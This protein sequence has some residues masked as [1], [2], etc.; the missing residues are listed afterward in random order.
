MNKTVILLFLFLSAMFPF[1]CQK[2]GGEGVKDEGP[3]VMVMSFNVRTSNIR[4]EK[5]ENNWENRRDACCAMINYTRPVL[6]GVQ[7][8]RKEQRD[9]LS[10]HCSGYEVLGQSRSEDGNDE[11]TAIFYLKD[12]VSVESSGTFWLSDTP[13]I[14]SKLKEAGHYRTATWIKARHTKSGKVFY[15]INTHLD[16]SN[17]EVRA[18]EME[19]ILDF[20]GRNCG[21]DPVVMT[22]D[23][24]TEDESA[25]F[26]EMYKTF[27]NARYTAS[28][29]DKGT[30]FNDYGKQTTVWQIDHIF[31]R[32]FDSCSKFVVERKAWEGHMYISD[33]YPV[34]STLNF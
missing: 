11:Q 28:S 5:N 17:N 7:E 25:V 24:N 16:N 20:V 9:Y 15:H 19:Y 21:D 3:T 8:C 6:M 1:S 12:S 29:T 27:K 32:G 33:H 14:V 2:N 34:Y 13:D 30:T 26:T 4:E 18:K 22:A 23:W 31:Y 10:R